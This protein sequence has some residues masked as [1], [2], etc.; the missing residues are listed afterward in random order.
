MPFNAAVPSA[1]GSGSAPALSPTRRRRMARD[2][3]GILALLAASL[4]ALAWGPATGVA[5]AADPPAAP[6]LAAEGVVA[7]REVPVVVVPLRL[8]ITG[9]RDTQVE[10]TVLRNLDRLL[11]RPGERGVLVLRFDGADEAGAGT[12]DFARSLALARFLADPRV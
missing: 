9:N 12:S 2:A 6:A 11:S 1:A 10:G 4:T 8:P 7:P 3:V 5:A